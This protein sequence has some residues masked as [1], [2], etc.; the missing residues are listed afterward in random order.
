MTM[1]VDAAI[2][3]GGVVGLACAAAIARGG[4][5]TVVL[6]KFRALGSVT[7]SRNSE[8]IHAGLYYAP[9]SLK[10]TTCVRGAELLYAWCAA[11]Q[12]P[13]ARCGK[14]VVATSD[15]ETATLEALEKNATHNGADVVLVGAHRARALEPN[16][17]C[18]AALHSPSTGIVDS[19]ALVASLAAETEAHGVVLAKGRAVVAIERAGDRW[20]LACEGPAGSER[21]TA[22]RVVNAAGL[23]ADELAALFG[24]AIE[25][26]FVKGSYFRSKRALVR[27][28]VYPLP[29]GD[30]TLG[31]HATID[32]AGAVRFGPD[33]EPARSREDYAVEET[34]RA[35]F[36]A[37]VSRYLPEI[38]EDDL[39]PDTCGVRPKV[40]GGDF[41]LLDRDGAVHLA[42]IESPGLTA[43]LALAERVAN[44]IA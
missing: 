34:H 43:A 41:V 44:M 27:S 13:H 12:V 10:A 4:K 35:A 16:V 31:V 15:G 17:R 7:T 24:V 30:G 18:V 23:W 22:A 19:H 11:R 33:A 9:G 8:V 1:E 37:A 21:V 6:E 28:L 5:S 40:A 32:L 36:H 39:E 26:R 14:L 3:G 20:T 2:I 42:G 29:P 25:Q 38:R